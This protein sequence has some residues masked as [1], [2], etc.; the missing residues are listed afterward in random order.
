MPPGQF[1]KSRILAVGNHVEHWLNDV[2]V[3]E[4][5]LGSQEI[6]DIVERSKFRFI[7]RFGEKVEAPILFQDHGDEFWLRNIRIRPIGK[8]EMKTMINK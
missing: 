8:N 1:N 6:L 7:E 3:L 2:K 4:Y 5:E